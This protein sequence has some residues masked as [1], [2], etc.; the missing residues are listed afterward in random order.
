[1]LYALVGSELMLLIC[2]MVRLALLLA[3]HVAAWVE[4]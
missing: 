1:M 3:R 2:W 4:P